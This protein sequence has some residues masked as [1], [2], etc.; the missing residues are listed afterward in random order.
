MVDSHFR[1]SCDR[2]RRAV[3][4]LLRVLTLG[5]SYSLCVVSLSYH[6]RV[7]R[8]YTHANFVSTDSI[9]EPPCLLPYPH[10]HLPPL[11]HCRN[12]TTARHTS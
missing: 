1:R 7:P 2:M 5:S 6:S 12:R 11:L 10:L 8:H 9:S 4:L 3:S